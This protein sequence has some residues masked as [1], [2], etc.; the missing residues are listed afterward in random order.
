M[1]RSFIIK[2]GEEHQEPP[3]D[4]WKVLCEK[5]HIS[6]EWFAC[7]CSPIERNYQILVG[8]EWV[9]I[10]FCPFCGLEINPTRHLKFETLDSIEY[11]CSL[12]DTF[13]HGK[14]VMVDPDT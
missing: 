10:L 13:P 8:G 1:A 12:K 14:I 7:D 3:C 9:D 4:K 6:Y 5:R 11:K 2:A